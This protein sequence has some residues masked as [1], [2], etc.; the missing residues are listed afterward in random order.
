MWSLLPQFLKI[1]KKKHWCNNEGFSMM[2]ER[3]WVGS[4][5]S[6]FKQPELHSSG[7]G[8]IQMVSNK[9]KNWA[10]VYFRIFTQAQSG[11]STG[12]TVKEGVG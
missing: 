6:H 3:G 2:G 11:G 4:H 9:G 7:S 8:G 12:A 1:K 10:H 5:V